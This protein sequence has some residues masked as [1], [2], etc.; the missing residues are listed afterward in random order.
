MEGPVYFRLSRT[1]IPLIYNAN[2]KFALGSAHELKP[3]QDLT[4]IAT[5][6]M[7]SLASQ[8]EAV[9]SQ[10]GIYPRLLNMF[11]IKPLDERAVLKAVQETGAIRHGGRTQCLRRLGLRGGGS[12]G[13]K[14]PCPMKIMSFPDR[15]GETGGCGE[16]L[17]ALG[18]PVGS[19]S[20]DAE[21][22][23]QRKMQ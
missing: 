12:C 10:R 14:A 22:L 3:G 5:G 6:C 20:A 7:V 2:F 23:W 21:N 16:V 9:L 1:E 18:L 19:I 8:A 4:I 11:T 15:F 17:A 13:P